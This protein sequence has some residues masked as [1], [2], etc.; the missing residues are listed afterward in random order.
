MVDIC[1]LAELRCSHS[2]CFYMVPQVG[3]EPTRISP[4]ASKTSVATITPPG[5]IEFVSSSA[6]LIRNHF[7]QYT[8]GLEVRSN[9]CYKVVALT[10]RRDFEFLLSQHLHL[11]NLVRPP[12][13]E[14][15]SMVLQTTAMTTSAKAA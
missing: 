9:S 3:L 13:I 1:K 5:L 14:P 11:Q 8:L 4:L 12:G 10:T 2:E 6:S 7:A 15:G